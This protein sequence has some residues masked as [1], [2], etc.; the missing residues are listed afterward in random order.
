M[1]QPLFQKPDA[2]RA[3]KVWEGDGAWGVGA[4][5][6]RYISMGRDVLTKGVLFSCLSG[7]WVCFII[8]KNLCLER[9]G[10]LP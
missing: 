4:G 3:K 5:V 8:A 6:T 2:G 10:K 9:G 1:C 7:T